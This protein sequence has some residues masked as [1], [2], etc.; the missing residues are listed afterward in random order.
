MDFK[1]IEENLKN[2]DKQTLIAAGS[3]VVIVIS[4]LAYKTYTSPRNLI[5]FSTWAVISGLV[6]ES[7]R[8]SK[9]KKSALI[10]LLWAILFSFIIFI[11][12]EKGSLT[13]YDI[14]GKIATWPAIFILS[15]T[16]T[17]M[18]IFEKN[19]ITKINIQQTVV[20]CLAFAYL[21]F[22]NNFFQ[23]EYLEDK[24]G[25]TLLL[26]STL[27]SVYQL[28]SRKNLSPKIQ[29]FLSSLTA[30]IMVIFAAY[31]AFVLYEDFR[32]EMLHK[33][34][35]R[36]VYFFE[37]FALGIALVY[38]LQNIY[39]LYDFVNPVKPRD[40]ETNRQIIANHVN[41]FDK[42]KPKTLIAFILLFY[43][44]LA[45]VIQE[46]CAL[47]ATQS[48]TAILIFIPLFVSEMHSKLFP[49]ASSKD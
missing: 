27:F 44:F 25:I 7:L 32:W 12:Y 30:L 33:S 42:T 39:L 14:Y 22:S 36:F 23:S 17:A 9:L 5:D 47:L 49:S 16:L 15:F 41:R 38:T 6:F 3:V 31:Y 18:T 35:S 19:V 45:I 4:F 8:L 48:F 21:L 46:T 40:S 2:P 26:A 28:F 24:I 43:M 1:K 13:Y 10:H 20:I 37:F 34:K 11:P 29:V